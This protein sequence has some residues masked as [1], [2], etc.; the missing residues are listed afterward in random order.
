M[1]KAYTLLTYVAHRLPRLSAGAGHTQ[2][3]SLSSVS[4]VWE[5]MQACLANLSTRR[6]YMSVACQA[7][8]DILP[9]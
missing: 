4:A 9:F 2:G 5:R 8:K 1:R 3:K 6:L 7:R